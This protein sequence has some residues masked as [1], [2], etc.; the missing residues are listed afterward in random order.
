LFY[1][2][3]AEHFVLQTKFCISNQVFH[4]KNHVAVFIWNGTGQMT[5][6]TSTSEVS[7]LSPAKQRKLEVAS[8]F[9]RMNLPAFTRKHGEHAA[10]TACFEI[11]RE[12]T[13][14]QNVLVRSG[15]Q[16]KYF[17]FRATFVIHL[18]SCLRVLAPVG[19]WTTGEPGETY[20]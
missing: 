5:T 15:E 4:I 1:F 13:N 7:V 17:F 14:V 9:K 19:G 20:G 8:R 6:S 11:I 16:V 2:D 3:F 10:V 12:L 18:P